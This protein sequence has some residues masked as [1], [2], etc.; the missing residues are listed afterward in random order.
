MGTHPAGLGSSAK[1]AGMSG[2][3]LGVS[4]CAGVAGVSPRHFWRSEAFT[5]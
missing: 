5:H 1:S 3:T 2:A 4:G